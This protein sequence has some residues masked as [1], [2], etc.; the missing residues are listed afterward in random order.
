MRKIINLFVILALL[1]GAVLVGCGKV[2]LPDGLPTLETAVTYS[3]SELTA[4]LVGLT[5][6]QMS[7]LWGNPSTHVSAANS[8]VWVVNIETGAKIVVQYQKKDGVWI[9]ERAVTGKS[10]S[11]AKSYSYK[12]RGE[13]YGGDFVITLYTD[14][15]FIYT[16][17]KSSDYVGRGLWTQE[18]NGAICLKENKDENGFARTNYFTPFSNLLIWVADGSDNF[19]YVTVKAGSIF[20]TETPEVPDLKTE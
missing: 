7:V 10:T 14:G 18:N 17:G 2:E 20:A 13:G 12:Y 15:T 16:E 9:V 6:K 1:C 19:K 4:K 8:D 5:E 11:M 3:D